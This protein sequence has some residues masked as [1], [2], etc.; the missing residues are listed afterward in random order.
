MC[1]AM[2][3][4]VVALFKAPCTLNKN[5]SKLYEREETSIIPYVKLQS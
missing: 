5:E 1:V 4:H 2:Q 3:W